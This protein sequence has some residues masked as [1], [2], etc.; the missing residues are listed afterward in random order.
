[1][2]K[3][4]YYLGEVAALLGW[5]EQ[6]TGTQLRRG[7]IPAERVGARGRWRV[8]RVALHEFAER[9]A[10]QLNW[11]ALR[12]LQEKRAATRGVRVV[13]PQPHHGRSPAHVV[14]E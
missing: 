9:E 3:H 12:R 2:G 4:F 7:F 8:R 5:S 6:W 13:V 14:A 1:V 11:D 10:V